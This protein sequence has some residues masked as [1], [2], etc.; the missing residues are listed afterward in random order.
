MKHLYYIGILCLSLFVISCGNSGKEVALRTGAENTTA[1]LSL[2][3]G[4]KVGIL[5]NHTA[6]IGDIHL[7]DHLVSHGIDVRMIFGPEHGF[8]GDADAG[9]RFDHHVDEATGI[10][11][12]S[13]YGKTLIPADEY[14]QELDIAVFDIQD[15]GLR[16]YTYLS[17][18]YYLMEAC[19]RNDVPLIILD[20]PNPNGHIVSG[21]VL[22]SEKYTSFVGIAPIPVVH[23]MT[24]GEM[25]GM[26]NGEHW[27][28]DNLQADI[29]V[30]PCTGYTH[31][32]E[33]ILPLK[34]SPNLPNNRSIYLYPSI[35]LFEG[36]RASLGRGTEFPFQV[37]GHPLMVGYDFTFTPVPVP[38][39]MRPILKDQL[40]FGVDL[41]TEPSD[42][43]VRARG[44]DLSYIVDAYTNLK[45]HAGMDDAFFTAY[46]DK[47]VGVDYVRPM[48]QEGVP[49]EEIEALWQE[50]LE[51]FKKQR[52]PYLLYPL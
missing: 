5:T 19:A 6:T 26:I 3:E 18:M 50:D 48:I 31:S 28:P 45:E 25:A 43:Y 30:I 13:V 33:Y 17:S 12:V 7:V 4:K 15:V 16:F 8:R 2:L 47:L 35:C 40:C 41:R 29:T 21:P 20:R 51:A 52:E 24:L 11:V 34:P 1:Y 46:F 10:P 14:M 27:L 49:I 42:E 32:T 23:G 22:D 37:Y 39:A 44:F 36:T 38:G 9:R